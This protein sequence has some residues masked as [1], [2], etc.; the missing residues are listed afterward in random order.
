MHSDILCCLFVITT[1]LS[2]ASVSANSFAQRQG[3]ALTRQKH[4]SEL[5]ERGSSYWLAAIGHNGLSPYN[6]DP[7]YIV[8][9]NVQHAP[10]GAKGDGVTDDTAAIQK[11]LIDGDACATP[12]CSGSTLYPKLVYLPP[13]KYL[14]SKTLKI[15]MYTQLVGSPLSPPTI[16][17]SSSFGAATVLDGFPNTNGSYWNSGDAPLNFYKTVRNINIDTTKVPASTAVTC[18]NWAVSQATSLRSMVFKMA[19]NSAHVGVGMS[20]GGSGTFVGDLIFQGGAIGL[21]VRNQQFHFR[22]L[23]FTG[24]ATAISTEYLFIGVFQDISFTNCPIG[25]Q[26]Q[27]AKFGGFHSISLIDSTA[28][29]VGTLIMA[30]AQSTS[31]IRPVVIDNLSTAKVTNILVTSTPAKTTI[32]LAGNAAGS[33]SVTGYARGTVYNQTAVFTGGQ[34]FNGLFKPSSMLTG[35]A[36]HWYTKPKPVYPTLLAANVVNIKYHGVVGDGVTDDLAAIQAVINQYAGTGKMVYFPYGVYRISATLYAPPG[37]ILQGEAWS[38]IRADSGDTSFWADEANPQPVLQIGKPGDEGTF[39][40]SDMDVEPGNVY[41]GAKLVEINMLGAAGDVGIW[42]CV[43]RTGGTA[44]ADDQGQLCTTNGEECKSAWGFVHIT[45][46]GNAYLENVWGW[47]ADHA[48]DNTPGALGTAIQTGRGALVQSRAATFFVGVAMEHCTFYSVNEYDAKNLWLGM[49]QDETPYWQRGN[50]APS[51]W[52]PNAAY[53]DPDFSN[54]ATGDVDCRLAF[55]LHFDGGQ[56]IYSYGSGVWTFAPTQTNDI[57]VTDKKR[58]NLVIFN[59]NNGGTGG[60]W[61][62]IISVVKGS[63]NVTDAGNPGSWAG[64]VTAAYLR[65]AT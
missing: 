46:Y 34:N 9:R 1:L 52:T 26:G 61:T 50:I 21:V 48:I 38:S 32:L 63:L 62:N 64:G 55:G 29:N 5:A 23:S 4:H 47:N 33:L 53:H 24:C 11:A 2:A 31:D 20:G 39:V 22:N 35:A 25:I 58:S 14:V 30:P 51:G 57:W 6:I 54:C 36:K 27:P 16:V 19:S 40:M 13:G 3:R 45:K 8:Y 56:N 15:S 49:I 12:S 18:V 60:Q 28:T 37:T 59:A 65:Y 10:Y 7:S 44:S 42:D 41:P 17:A 43:F